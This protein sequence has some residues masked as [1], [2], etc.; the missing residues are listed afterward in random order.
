MRVVFGHHAH[1]HDGVI[2]L[3][4]DMPC[5]AAPHFQVAC[6]WYVLQSQCILRR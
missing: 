4:S 2:T 6:S 1:C 5:M 3:G